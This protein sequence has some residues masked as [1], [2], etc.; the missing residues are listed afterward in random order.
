MFKF[1]LAVRMHR[2]AVSATALDFSIKGYRAM[3]ER[4]LGGHEYLSATAGGGQFLDIG[5]GGRPL[6]VY[7]MAASLARSRAAGGVSVPTSRWPARC[8][9]TT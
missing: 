9:S 8:T 3:I 2:P 7:N 6:S 4:F 1:L 5:L